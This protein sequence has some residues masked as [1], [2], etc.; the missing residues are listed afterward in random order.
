VLR[1]LYAFLS[2]FRRARP[3][4]I[5]VSRLVPDRD[6]EPLWQLD[7]RLS[8]TPWTLAD[9]HRAFFGDEESSGGAHGLV[10]ADSPDGRRPVL[11]ALVFRGHD[12]H[13]PRLEI[14]RAIRRASR[15][16][17]LE[18]VLLTFLSWADAVHPCRPIY[19]P[20]REIEVQV[21]LRRLGCQAIRVR[22]RHFSKDEDAY[23]FDPSGMAAAGAHAG[24]EGPA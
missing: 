21:A 6:L 8:P 5:S 2:R 18:A 1:R 9:Y 15:P 20:E 22:A 3:P 11:A 7:K 13:Q 23:V 12:L 24:A 14:R 16:D 19:V 10:A 4:R 17:A